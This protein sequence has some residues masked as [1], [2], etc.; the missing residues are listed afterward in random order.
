MCVHECVLSVVCDFA[1]TTCVMVTIIVVCSY[2]V[3]LQMSS[4]TA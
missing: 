2:C 1:S 3:T 4:S